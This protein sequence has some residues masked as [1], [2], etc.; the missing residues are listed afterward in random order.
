MFFFNLLYKHIK[1]IEKYLKNINLIPFKVKN[2]FNPKNKHSF[3]FL[4]NQQGYVSNLNCL[5]L[6]GIFADYQGFFFSKQK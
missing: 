2:M 4:V 6:E 3:K 1:I 5:K